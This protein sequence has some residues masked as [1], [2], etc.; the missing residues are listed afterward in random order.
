MQG[1]S[2]NTHELEARLAIR[3][4]LHRAGLAKASTTDSR[5]TPPPGGHIC[6]VLP[7]VRIAHERVIQTEVLGC[8]AT[9][10]NRAALVVRG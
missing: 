6:I 3:S 1:S 2:Q 10:P 8:A 5:Q 4:D 7:N 9:D